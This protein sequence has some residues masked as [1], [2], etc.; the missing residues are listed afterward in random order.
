M[1]SD[2]EP[3]SPPGK[4]AAHSK[5]RPFLAGLGACEQKSHAAS[6]T[7]LRIEYPSRLSRFFDSGLAQSAVCAHANARPRKIVGR[8]DCFDIQPVPSDSLLCHSKDDVETIKSLVAFG[9]GP[10]RTFGVDS[11][12]ARRMRRFIRQCS[13]ELKRHARGRRFT[14][15]AVE[16]ELSLNSLFGRRVEH[17]CHRQRSA[18]FCLTSFRTSFR[19]RGRPPLL[20]HRIGWPSHRN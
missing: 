18:N 19:T 9:L 17:A 15:S 16:H 7:E 11:A 13:V 3:E 2:S 20:R 10:A 4:L 1:Q 12:T 8:S 14:A 5:R 6:P